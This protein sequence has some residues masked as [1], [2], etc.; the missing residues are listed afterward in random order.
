[1]R[2]L[3]LN[4]FYP[5]DVAATGQLLGDVAG[6]LAQ[7]GHEVHVLCSRGAY[8]GG[9]VERGP[10]AAPEGV[11]VHRVAACGFGR[12]NLPGRIA[13]YVS[14]YVLA[15]WRAI[16]VGRMDVCLCLTTPPFI[17]LVGLVLRLLRGTRVVLWSMDLYPQVAIAYGYIKPRCPLGKLM[18]WL[19]R[20]L[21]RR[22]SKVIAL[23]EVMAQ[24]LA[25]AG[26]DPAAIETVHNWVPGEIVSPMPP[27]ESK[28]RR[29]WNK[30]GRVTLMYS[31][32][33]GVGHELDTVLHAANRLDRSANLRLLFVGEG[34][35]RARLIALAGELGLNNVG[36]CPS[37]PLAA[38]SDSLAAGDIH[39][40][41]Q[42]GGTE[43]LIVPSKLY[44]IMAAGRPVVF[45]GP[46]QCEVAQIIRDSGSGIIV[47][48]GDCERAAEA[49]KSLIDDRPLRE[50]MG[51]RGKE[52]YKRH[53]GLRRS[54]A[55]I[56]EIIE[57]A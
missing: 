53:F 12:R 32:N 19:S 57:N 55:A 46:D 44:G 36:F 45:I 25:A 31:G 1:M 29:K 40:I 42:R 48:C 9:P 15:M 33:L 51:A 2:I 37:Q 41:S 35:M 20:R 18:A 4:Q 7:R 10:D 17:G 14:F 56:A 24:R 43:G 27:E 21:Y 38:L 16:A 47:A 22:A 34:K 28:A 39:V 11:T 13:D 8:A 3:L 49:I 5:P 30:D 50:R 6:A 54:V 26:A 23:G 52:F